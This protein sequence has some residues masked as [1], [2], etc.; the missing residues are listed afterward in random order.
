MGQLKDVR[1]LTYLKL[2]TTV[3]GLLY[4]IFQVRIF[5]TTPEIESYF[6]ATS[7][8]YL[9]TTFTQSGQLAEIFL[10]TY[11]NVKTSDGP[12]EAHRAFSVVINR[13]IIGV[14][15]L[16]II[17]LLTSSILVKLIVPGFSSD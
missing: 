8:M 17:G 4:S 1:T 7:L 11:L 16:L 14:L 5:G 9:I 3:L 2:I 10:P 15:I 12:A 13:L 6:A